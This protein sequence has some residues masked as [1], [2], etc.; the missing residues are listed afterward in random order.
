MCMVF[1]VEDLSAAS[2]ATVSR[3]GMI[4]YTPF[5]WPILIASLQLPNGYDLDY[6]IRRMRL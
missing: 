4:Y 2:P 5:K 3:C 1:E 6:F